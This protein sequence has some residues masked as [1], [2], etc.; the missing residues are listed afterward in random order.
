MLRVIHCAI[1]PRGENMFSNNAGD[2]SEDT[3]AAKA[4]PP[5]LDREDVMRELG[6]ELAKIVCNKTGKKKP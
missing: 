2:S 4:P 6:R 1:L 5:P 3:P